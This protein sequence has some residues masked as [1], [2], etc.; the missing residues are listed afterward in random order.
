MNVDFGSFSET[1][2]NYL[3]VSCVP[4]QKLPSRT[5][6]SASNGC[7]GSESCRL[8]AWI[9]IGS[10]VPKGDTGKLSARGNLRPDAAAQQPEKPR[11]VAGLNGQKAI[12]LKS[13]NSTHSEGEVLIGGVLEAIVEG[14]EPRMVV[15]V[16]GLR[17]TPVAVTGKTAHNILIHI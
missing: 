2:R 4:I 7:L 17:G 14:L 6:S 5:I 13:P 1:R 11:A 9:V 12:W 16:T 10:K 15:S 8:C 3:G